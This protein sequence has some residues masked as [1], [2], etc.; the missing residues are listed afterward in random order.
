LLFIFRL[1]EIIN[2]PSL[3]NLNED[4]I[5]LNHQDPPALLVYGERLS[6][7][8][9]K[10]KFILPT[11][12]IDYFKLITH[13]PE[14]R[15]HFIEDH[16]KYSPLM[17]SGEDHR[18]SR[19]KLS[20]LYTSIENNC[21]HWLSHF[22]Q[23]FFAQLNPA[24]QNFDPV[25]FIQKYIASVFNQMILLELELK[26]AVVPTYLGEI[27]HMFRSIDELNEYE[28]K[29]EVLVRFI[30][31]ALIKQKKDPKDAWMLVTIAVMGTE[32]L[33]GAFF[34]GFMHEHPHNKAWDAFSL[35]RASSPVSTLS[36]F[37]AKD[38]TIDGLHF[39]KDQLIY[40]SPDLIHYKMK[41]FDA[42]IPASKSYSFSDGPHTCPGLRIAMIIADAF[43]LAW[44][45][46]KPIHLNLEKYQFQRDFILRPK[47]HG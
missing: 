31:D 1:K 36:R 6:K 7:N 12:I 13:Q 39:K 9:L 44:H 8:I 20:K 30:E 3:I 42:S 5:A 46:R 26:D 14:A 43:M 47:I 33:L 29:L 21:Q 10:S 32:P 18:E 22:T 23:D 24:D 11:N 27:L 2:Q 35:F 15:F 28:K 25:F 34:Y 37:L 40:L 38:A 17:L 41:A 19:K 45:E 4:Y 16:F